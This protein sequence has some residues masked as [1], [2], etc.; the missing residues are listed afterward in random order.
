MLGESTTRYFATVEEAHQIEERLRE[1][2]EEEAELLKELER[3]GV[4]AS[5]E[6]SS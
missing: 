2:D 4:D 1:I 5:E 6:R 3:R